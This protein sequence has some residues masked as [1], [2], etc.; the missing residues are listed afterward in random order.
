M[1]KKICTL[2]TMLV[3]LLWMQ[4]TLILAGWFVCE[5]VELQNIRKVFFF[6]N[7]NSQ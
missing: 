4:S 1:A 5:F 3:K 2:Y 7:L 6:N